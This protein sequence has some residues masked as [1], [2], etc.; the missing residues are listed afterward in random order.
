[1]IYNLKKPQ[2]T[3]GIKDALPSMQ[4]ELYLTMNVYWINNYKIW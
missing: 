1:M 3:F 2:N 4:V